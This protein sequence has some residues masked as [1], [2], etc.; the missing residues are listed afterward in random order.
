MKYTFLS[1]VLG[2]GVLFG[3]GQ[4][5]PVGGQG[6]T[7]TGGGTAAPGAGA[8]IPTT[9]GRTPG[10]NQQQGPFDP[11]Q[12]QQQFPDM[13]RPIFLSGKVVLDD[14]TPPPEPVKIERVC[15]GVVR[16]E[17]YTDSKGRFSF[18]LGQNTSMMADA[19]VSS[20]GGDTFGDPM[21]RGGNSRSGMGGMGMPG[22]RGISER[23][24]MG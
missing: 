18:Q 9:P 13:Q 4:N 16:P 10:Q 3:Q 23:D 11:R 14:G 20:A 7:G 5:A 8:T 6:S 22:G 24:L 19:S 12:Q 2:L 15:N 17:G 21:S 1:L